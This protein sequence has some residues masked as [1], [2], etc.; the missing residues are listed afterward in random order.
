V[1]AHDVSRRTREIGVRIAL[2]ARRD[3][4][5]RMVVRDGVKLS[6]AGLVLGLLLGAGLAKILPSEV[7]GATGLSAIHYAAAA[8]V[9]LAIAVVAS[10]VPA[11]RASLVEPVTA[12]RAE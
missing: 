7:F 5:V 9:W 1:I 12:L 6:G 10:L 8:V 3:E 4:V 11:R 2:G